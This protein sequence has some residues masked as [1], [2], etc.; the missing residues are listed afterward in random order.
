MSLPSVEVWCRSVYPFSS[1]KWIYTPIHNL[2]ISD[3]YM[4]DCSAKIGR[5]DISNQQSETRV[6]TKLVMTVE[7]E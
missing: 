4:Y 1:Y 7:L 5:E 6:Y 2:K 3:L